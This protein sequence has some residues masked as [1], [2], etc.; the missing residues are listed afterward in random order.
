MVSNA[1]YL[2]GGDGAFAYLRDIAW[3]IWQTRRTAA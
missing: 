1:S 2:L 3:Q